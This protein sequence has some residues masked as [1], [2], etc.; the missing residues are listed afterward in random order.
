MGIIANSVA[1]KSTSC[2]ATNQKALIPIAA[3]MKAALILH[4]VVH[5]KNILRTISRQIKI[6]QMRLTSE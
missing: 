2:A 5:Q 1:A 6:N 4:V 3:S